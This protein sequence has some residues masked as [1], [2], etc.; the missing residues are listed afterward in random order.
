L[1]PRTRKKASKDEKTSASNTIRVDGCALPSH[2]EASDEV[3]IP[4]PVA[5]ESEK[6]AIGNNILWGHYDNIA[7]M[8][9]MNWHKIGWELQCLRNPNAD[10]T[11]DAI[12]VAF[13]PLRDQSGHELIPSLLRPTSVPATHSEL[14]RT[15]KSLVHARRQLSSAQD[16]YD[17]ELQ[18]CQET[19]SAVREADPKQ[20][21]SLQKDITRCSSNRLRFRKECQTT[22]SRIAIARE[23]LRKAEPPLR[24]AAEIEISTLQAAHEKSE[25]ALGMEEKI[26]RDLR[27]RYDDA[28]KQNLIWAKEAAESRRAELSQLDKQLQECRS[29]IQRIETMYENQAAGFARQ[30]LL[31]FIE[32]HRCIH[33]PGQLARAIA[34]LPILSCRKSFTR[35]GESPFSH[36]PHQNYE[37]FEVIARAWDK[38]DPNADDPQL[39]IQLF[40][41]E[42]SG[43]PK[44]KKWHGQ[45]V[46][47]FVRGKFESNRKELREAIRGCL[48]LK[49]LPGAVPYIITEMFLDKI[50]RQKQQQQ[51]PLERILSER[52]KED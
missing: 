39:H 18:K 16:T 48:R 12:K 51:T 17:S 46:P 15:Y 4:E 50:S 8:L 36:E 19:D 37:L 2:A 35:C 40:E 27:K 49:S 44:T 38:R 13:E 47:N 26:L 9:E 52:R 42:I 31:K 23:K 7:Y 21:K 1:R 5:E 30:D 24:E 3:E 22:Q 32:E 10:R 45:E 33:H 20:R 25:Q 34:G 28:T 11:P 6:L 14:Q 29:E 43:L 41:D